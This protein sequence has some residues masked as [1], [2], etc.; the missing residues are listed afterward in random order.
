MCSRTDVPALRNRPSLV[1]IMRMSKKRQVCV[2]CGKRSATT[3]D[4]VPPKGIFPKPRPNDLITV[5]ACFSCNHGASRQ[6]EIFRVNLS[7][8]A[9]VDAPDTK[10]LWENHAL[11]TVKHNRRLRRKLVSGMRPVYVKSTGGIILRKEGGVLWDSVAHDSVINRI[12]R[13]L[14]FHHYGSILP[15]ESRIKVNWHRLLTKEMEEES[16]ARGWA[17]E[18]IAGGHFQ[19]RYGR[20]EINQVQS[21]WLFQ[22]YG[23]HWASGHTNLKS[24]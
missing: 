5:P 8:H 16:R 2:L 22:F 11:R 12:I 13:G 7:L 4:H 23:R 9:G 24:V 10:A 15:P 17:H 6:D 1:A 18:S 19:Y 20:S 14:Y 3:Q 21:I